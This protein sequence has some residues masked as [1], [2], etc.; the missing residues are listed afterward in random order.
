MIS[1]R[2]SCNALSPEYPEAELGETPLWGLV[3]CAGVIAAGAVE[4]VD[5]DEVLRETGFRGEM[6][7]EQLTVE[8]IQALCEGFRHRLQL[9]P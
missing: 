5:I 3:N 8:E 1:E 2:C 9:D 6:R 4:K 7:A